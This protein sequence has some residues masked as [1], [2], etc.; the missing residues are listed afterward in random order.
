MNHANNEN[1]RQWPIM[2]GLQLSESI[3]KN[4]KVADP[5]VCI[6][7]DTRTVIWTRFVKL[8]LFW[9]KNEMAIFV[10]SPMTDYKEAYGHFQVLG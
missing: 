1:T 4:S 7:R 10:K 3:F 2:V 8:S 5:F 6:Q 9:H